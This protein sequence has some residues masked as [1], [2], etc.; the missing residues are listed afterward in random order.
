MRIL[1]GSIGLVIA[2]PI[3]TLIAAWI[4]VRKNKKDGSSSAGTSA[5]KTPSPVDENVIL[6]GSFNK[7][8]FSSLRVGYMILPKRLVDTVLAFRVDADGLIVDQTR[9]VP[10]PM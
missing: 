8:L 9:T 7:L 10:M 3:T 4:V 6:I 1:I 2:V 5:G